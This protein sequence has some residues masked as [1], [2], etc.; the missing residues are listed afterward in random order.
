M[1]KTTDLKILQIMPADGWYAHYI[2][3]EED[4][5]SPL[6]C[7]ALIEFDDGHHQIL[8]MITEKGM[9]STLFCT[10]DEGFTRYSREK[11]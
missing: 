11:K 4:Y 5:I 2:V 6:V 10:S 8:G 3:N 7:W 9:T 1:P